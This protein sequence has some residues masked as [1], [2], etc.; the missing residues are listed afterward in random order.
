MQ[1]RNNN[2]IELKFFVKYM[3]DKLNFNTFF[4]IYATAVF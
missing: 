3:G 4:I 1:F 2:I